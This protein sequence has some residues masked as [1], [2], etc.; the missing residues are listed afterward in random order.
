ML[1]SNCIQFL[2][3]ILQ[4]SELYSFRVSNVNIMLRYDEYVLIANLFA[5]NFKA[6]K[7]LLKSVNMRENIK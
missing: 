2:L 1:V 3:T 7:F 5:Q 4:A 6:S